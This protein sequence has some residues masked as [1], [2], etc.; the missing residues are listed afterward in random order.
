MKNLGELGFVDLEA[1]KQISCFNKLLGKWS[2]G[3][4]I[5][6]SCFDIDYQGSTH[7]E[8]EAKGLA[9]IGLGAINTKNSPGP[10]YGGT[11]VKHGG[12]WL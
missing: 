3:S 11:L 10:R 8:V 7:E 6:N 2:Q 12:L 1:T 4:I 5:F 9:W